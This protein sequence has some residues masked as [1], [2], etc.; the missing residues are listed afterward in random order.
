[1]QKGILFIWPNPFV[2]ALILVE[3]SLSA[4]FVFVYFKSE[5]KI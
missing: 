1:M 2:K 4:Y 5:M 3:I